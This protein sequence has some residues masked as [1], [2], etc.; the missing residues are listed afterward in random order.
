MQMAGS[1]PD[2]HF[3]IHWIVFRLWNNKEWEEVQDSY[4][5]GQITGNGKCYRQDL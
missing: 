2:K 4:L 3:Y 1:N 5:P